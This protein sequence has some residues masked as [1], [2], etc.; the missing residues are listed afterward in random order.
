MP[1]H[2]H[3]LQNPVRRELVDSL[4]EEIARLEEARRPA[5]EA[6]VSSGFGPLDQLLPA[7]GFHRGTLVEWLASGDGSGVES[8]AVSAAREACREGG[9]LVVFDPTREF[10]PPAA[11]RLESTRRA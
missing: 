7:R 6:V 1:P 8:M 2:I 11:V 9:A 4:R 10:Y 5:S 3:I